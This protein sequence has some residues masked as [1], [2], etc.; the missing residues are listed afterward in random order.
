MAALFQNNKKT[1]IDKIVTELRNGSRTANITEETS[2][3]IAAS[4][5]GGQFQKS[6]NIADFFMRRGKEEFY[7]EIKT[8]KSNI[9]VF[10]KSKTKLLE[11]VAR[12]RRPVKVF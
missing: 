3:V 1:V 9:D 6:G 8:V 11:W 10:E 12:K 4:S 7:F 5:S 2:E